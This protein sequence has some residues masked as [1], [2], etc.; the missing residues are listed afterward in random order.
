M[1]VRILL[2]A[3]AAA[4]VALGLAR[5]HHHRACAAAGRDAFAVGLHRLPASAG[6]AV[7][8][9]LEAQCRGAQQL[10]DGVSAMVRGGAIAPAAR[11]A[12]AAVRREPQRRDSWLALASVR[13]A[14]HDPT[15]ARRALD[16]ARQLDP[17]AFRR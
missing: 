6:D 1:V 14:Q 7:A 5:G 4:L 10:A 2:V 8:D 11:L 9:R 3:G 13:R 12:A 16:R 15:G 17:L